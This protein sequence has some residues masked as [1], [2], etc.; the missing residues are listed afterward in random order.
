[1]NT[2]YCRP[3]IRNT[4]NYL[5]KINNRSLPLQSN[6]MKNTLLVLAMLLCS[7]LSN[8]QSSK[9]PKPNP[10]RLWYTQS[11]TIWE[12]ALPIG[13][14]RL[15]AMVFGGVEED[16]IQFNE[17]T[18]WTG[19]PNDY[20]HPGASNYLGKI[21]ELLWQGKQGEAEKLAMD[22]FMSVPLTQRKYQ[23][24]GDIWMRFPSQG[25]VSNYQRELDLT[26]A[27]CRTSYQS[28]STKYSREYLASVPDQTIAIALNADKKGAITF[29][30]SLSALHE[31]FTTIAKND[32]TIELNVKVKDGVLT[33]TAKVR[34]M[35]K[36]GTISILQNQLHI[37]KADQATIY[38]VAATSFINPKDVSGK[39]ELL[40]NQYLSKIGTKK[41]E[42]VK[43]NHSKDYQFYFNRFS[44]DLGHAAAEN[45]PTDTRLKEMQNAMDLSLSALY[46]QYAR[47][48]MLSSSRPGTYPANLQGIWNN[49]TNPPWDSKYTVNIN[50]EMNYWAVETLNLSECHEALFKMI[51]EVIPSGEQVAKVHYNAKGWVLHH[52]TDLWR[53]AAPINHSNHGL[54]VSGIASIILFQNPQLET[55]IFSPAY[56]ESA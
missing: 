38:L 52:N 11:A 9:L 42:W 10:L 27:I 16:H 26:T 54:W 48:L 53:G 12:E 32:G 49:K 6:I 3:F 44:I 55:G 18:L 8:A 46:V 31:G 43:Q 20:A 35:T 39:P 24:F 30:L 29:D 14:G 50:T 23:P 33:G 40:C 41:F 21:R 25:G 4:L 47:Y 36:G 19:A 13:N 1:M 51:E 45:N 5:F 28:G 7:L 56:I 22:K 15:G 37:E 2:K 17:E 34:V